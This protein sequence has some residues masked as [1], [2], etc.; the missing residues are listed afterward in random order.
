MDILA[1]K[2]V[3]VTVLDEALAGIHHEDTAAM[4]SVLLVDNDDAG[5][6]TGTIE[7]VRRQADDGLDIA[8]A[9][10]VLSNSCFGI[11]SEQDT[12]RQN[13]GAPAP[14]VESLDDVQQKR[15]ITVLF[16]RDAPLETRE[17]IFLRVDATGPV[18]IRER[19]IGH[20]EI[21]CLQLT[22]GIVC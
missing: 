22:I 15:V 1:T 13:D 7:E 18:L 9:D 17:L 16:R 11:A 3:L 4:S 5:R 20:G 8:L 2:S 19:R 12:V 21:E 6:N 10:Q 14:T